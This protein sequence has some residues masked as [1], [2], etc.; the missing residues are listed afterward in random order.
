MRTMILGSYEADERTRLRLVFRPGPGATLTIPAPPETFG[1]PAAQ[2][3]FLRAAFVAVHGLDQGR[4]GT[5]GV[6][7]ES[8][9]VIAEIDR[10]G[11]VWREGVIRIGRLEAE[12]PDAD[13]VNR[14]DISPTSG[15]L[16]F[17]PK[18]ASLSR[19][20]FSVPV[21][22]TIS[23]SN[24][25]GSDRVMLITTGNVFL[26]A[27]SYASALDV[28]GVSLHD[29]IVLGVPD[30]TT[31]GSR[32]RYVPLPS[33]EGVLTLADAAHA[34]GGVEADIS[35]VVSIG[36]PDHHDQDRRF[37]GE[38]VYYPEDADIW[39]V[40]R[41]EAEE[42]GIRPARES[43]VATP[44]SPDLVEGMPPDLRDR[45]DLSAMT[46]F[47][48]LDVDTCGNPCVWMNHYRDDDGNEW[49]SA[50]SCQCEDEGVEPFRSEWIGPE[51]DLL[52]KLWEDLPEAG[53]PR[54]QADDS[55]SP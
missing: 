42:P 49:E 54:P 3:D 45:S 25:G 34:Y 33:P 36:L 39:A 21:V 8:G 5:A 4:P 10:H 55:P 35:T 50:W 20:D 47:R 37:D 43:G 22:E 6:Y 52:R 26:D 32:T 14:G 44:V 1:D 24:V 7:D 29:G 41:N 18:E 53:D 16:L 46:A 48:E 40:L 15:A 38:T 2:V 30:V 12:A 17:R 27:K 19:R 23:E 31:E 9:E 51:S 11:A 28:I 13:W